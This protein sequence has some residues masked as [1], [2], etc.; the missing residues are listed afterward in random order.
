MNDSTASRGL[1]ELV[2]LCEAETPRG[3]AVTSRAEKS[4]EEGRWPKALSCS[5]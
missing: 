5:P 3:E 1:R 2:L 4:C